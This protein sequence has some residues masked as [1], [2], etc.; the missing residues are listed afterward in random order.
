MLKVG[1]LLKQA[2]PNLLHLTCFAHAIHRVCEFVRE[3]FP[4]VNELIS[5]CKKILLKSPSRVSLYRA[6]CPN[7]PLPPKPV[8][9]RWGTWLQA[10]LFYAEHFQLIKS[11]VLTLPDEAVSIKDCK[12]ILMDAN[13]PQQVQFISTNFEPILPVIKSLEQQNVPLTSS[14][15]KFEH[16]FDQ[17]KAVEV[18]VVKK[19]EDNLHDII[20]RNPDYTTLRQIAFNSFTDDAVA[21]KYFHLLDCFA[22]APVTSCDVERSFSKFKDLLTAKRH[23]FTEENLEKFAIIQGFNSAKTR[24]TKNGSNVGDPSTSGIE[25]PVSSTSKDH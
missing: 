8:I 23:F 19:L 24:T 13:L 1:K 14:F 18:P 25:P 12:K 15:E 9:T 16:L 7:I 2:F 20:K 4:A 17:L 6:H 21:E 10:A 22:L 5:T 3:A 11:F